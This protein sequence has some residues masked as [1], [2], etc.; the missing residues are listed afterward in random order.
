M[1]RKTEQKNTKL[2]NGEKS[3]KN[4]YLAIA[5]S[6]SS[7]DEPINIPRRA[8]CRSVTVKHSAFMAFTNFLVT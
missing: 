3:M 8:F 7:G 2:D 6:R 4:P 5:A 1:V